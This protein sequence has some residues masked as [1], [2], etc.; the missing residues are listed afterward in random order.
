MFI[1]YILHLLFAPEFALNLHGNIFTVTCTASNDLIHLTYY[2]CLVILN[3]RIS[4]LE[5]I[6]CKI[7]GYG[8]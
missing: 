6:S 8:N 3:V 7:I 4:I 2:F 1:T 5:R